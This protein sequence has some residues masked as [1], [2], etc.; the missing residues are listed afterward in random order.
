MAK[1]EVQTFAAGIGGNE[2]AD[3]LGERQLHLL[4]LVHAH[5][6]IEARDG[7]AAIA[8]KLRQHFLRGHE[9][10][11]HEQLHVRVAFLLL[12]LVNPFEQRLGLGVRAAR[13]DLA[14]GGEEQL[15]LGALVLHR[16]EPRFQK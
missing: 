4:A 10:G 15:D 8:E 11:E 6:A 14:G 12:E 13:L 3:F 5:A 1:L 2:D 16:G 7:N 9:L